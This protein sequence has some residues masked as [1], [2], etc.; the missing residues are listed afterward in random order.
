MA[1]SFV[2]VGTDMFT[3]DLK[4]SYHHI[5]VAKDHHCYLG[6]SWVVPVSKKA[7]FHRLAVLPFGLS[8]APHVFTKVLKPLVKHWRL[9][10]ARIALFLDDSW[11][12]AS[13]RDACASLSKTVKDDLLSIGFVSIDD[14]SGMVVIGFACDPPIHV[15][16]PVCFMD[17]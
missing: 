11:G 13:T 12:I 15:V 7:Q 17:L 10:G 14:K 2:E 5:G 8:S 6:F 4:S 1:I 9:N 16:G 3:F